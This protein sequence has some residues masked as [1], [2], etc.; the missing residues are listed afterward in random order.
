MNKLDKKIFK[1]LS[2]F[3]NNTF[4]KINK[5]MLTNITKY[6]KNVSRTIE[7][8]IFITGYIKADD[9]RSYAITEKGLE[10]LRIL[11]NI[12]HKEKSMYISIIALLIALFTLFSRIWWF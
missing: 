9:I 8:H 1:A 7:N 6:Y 12:K 3:A 4:K 2:F 11:E 5:I 10:Q